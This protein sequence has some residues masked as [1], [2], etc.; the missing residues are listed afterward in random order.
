[1]PIMSVK[2][3]N[4]AGNRIIFED[5]YGTIVHKRSGEQD[6]FLARNGVYFMK[7]IVNRSLL[8]PPPPEPQSFHRPGRD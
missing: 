5:D 6:D 2:R 1:M 3:W 7:M 8:V 4:A